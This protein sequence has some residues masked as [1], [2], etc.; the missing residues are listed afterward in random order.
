MSYVTEN[1]YDIS[2]WIHFLRMLSFL[3]EPELEVR[4]TGTNGAIKHKYK[5][6]G[7]YYEQI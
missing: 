3:L 5:L 4:N 6:I 1:V 2:P 7:K